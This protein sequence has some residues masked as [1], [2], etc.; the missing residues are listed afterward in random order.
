MSN[1]LLWQ[2]SYAEIHVTPVCWPEFGKEELRI[3]FEDYA[4]RVRRFGGLPDEEHGQQAES[5]DL[6]GKGT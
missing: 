6:Q 4:Q 2:I 3:A 5:A 1:F